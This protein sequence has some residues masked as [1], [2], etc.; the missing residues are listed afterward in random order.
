MN[1]SEGIGNISERVGNGRKGFE[2]VENG[3]GKDWEW[4]N[5][6]RT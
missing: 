4:L 5:W 1:G 6:S 3:S 2:R